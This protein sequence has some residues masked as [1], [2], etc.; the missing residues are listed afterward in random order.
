MIKLIQQKIDRILN[1]YEPD[2]EMQIFNNGKLKAY[3]EILEILRIKEVIQ[4]N[5]ILK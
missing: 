4:N 2:N 3:E 5:K 1:S